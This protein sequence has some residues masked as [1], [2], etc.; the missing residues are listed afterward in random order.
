MKNPAR[1]KTLFPKN[2]QT[3][4]LF[5]F[6]KRGVPGGRGQK[7]KKKPSP[8]S[9]WFFVLLPFFWSSKKSDDCMRKR[10]IVAIASCLVPFRFFF[11]LFTGA[12]SFFRR[13]PFLSYFFEYRWSVR[14]PKSRPKVLIVAFSWCCRLG[15]PIDIPAANQWTI[16]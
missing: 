2:K 14:V 9:E 16:L 1:K 8:H 4:F 7:K 11:W 13:K 10:K 6:F 15:D 5:L 3:L 12:L